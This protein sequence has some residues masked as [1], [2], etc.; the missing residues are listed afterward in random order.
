[1]MLMSSAECLLTAS[2]ISLAFLELQRPTLE[3]IAFLQFLGIVS[4][5]EMLTVNDH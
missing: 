5:G 3:R 1:M 2:D 4:S